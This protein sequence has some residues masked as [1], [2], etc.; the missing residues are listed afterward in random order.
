MQVLIRVHGAVGPNIAAA[1]DDLDVRTETVLSGPVID[2]A[3]VHGLLGRL[4]GFGLSVLDVQVRPT[5]PGSPVES[6]S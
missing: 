6:P 3:A 1:F 4:Q 2:D 5:A